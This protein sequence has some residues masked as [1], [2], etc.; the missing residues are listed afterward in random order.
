MKGLRDTYSFGSDSKRHAK[1]LALRV[2]TICLPNI[3]FGSG[4]NPF[5]ETCPVCEYQKMAQADLP[6]PVPSC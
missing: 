6:C 4:I 3:L 5:S 2:L 1:A